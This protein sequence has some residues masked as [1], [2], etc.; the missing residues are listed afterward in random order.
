MRISGERGGRSAVEF[1]WLEEGGCPECQ[2][3]PYE[4]DGRLVWYCGEC[5]GGSA[6]LIPTQETPC[7]AG[8]G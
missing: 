1:D 8:Q 7:G 6:E 5:G 4:Q 2:P 3:E